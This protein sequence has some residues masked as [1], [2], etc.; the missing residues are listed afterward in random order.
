MLAMFWAL[1]WDLTLSAVDPTLEIEGRA[2]A[3]SIPMMVIAVLTFLW[4]W[5]EFLDPL[6]YISD[7]DRYTVQLGL[8]MLK[9]RYNIQWNLI[10]AGSLLGVVPPLLLYF[11]AQKQLIG[12]IAS[13]GIK[14]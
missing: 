11:V 6:I 13:V 5:N 9:G 12:G 10:M 8:N 7:Y 1:R 3:A 2:M 14:G 4:T